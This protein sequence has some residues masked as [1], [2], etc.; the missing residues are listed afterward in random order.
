MREHFKAL[1]EEM[2][3]Q[4]AIDYPDYQYSPRRPGEKKRPQTVQVPTNSLEFLRG[5]PT[6]DALLN[7]APHGLVTVDNQLVDCLDEA[8]VIQGANGMAPFGTT[9]TPGRFEE[10]ANHQSARRN[11]QAVDYSKDPAEN[12]QPE[13]ADFFVL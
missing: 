3:R 5:N 9:V 10:L 8:G 6:A 2:K 11:V 13:L 1:A 7:N 4:H 12:F